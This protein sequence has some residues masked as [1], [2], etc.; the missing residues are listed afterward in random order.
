MKKKIKSEIAT[1]II[2][3]ITMLVGWSFL[4]INRD[5][6]NTDNVQ[7]ENTAPITKS[8]SMEKSEDK[9]V[10][11]GDSITAL[12]D[13]NKLFGVSN[14]TNAGISGNAT[15]DVIARL[16]GVI[17][18]RPDKLF[19][20]IGINDLLQGKEVDYIV[21]NYG[22]ILDTIKLESP[23]TKIYVESVLPINNDILKS[24]TAS[25]QEILLLNEE[26]KKLAEKNNL[27]Y[28]DLYPLFASS[29][30]K[31]YRKYAG[32]GLHPSSVGYDVWKKA[33][34]QYIK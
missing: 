24:T 6:R 32:D 14:I 16:S 30:N 28:I 20:M 22:I 31:L 29:D 23:G 15:D 13:W 4:V 17:I 33:T 9:I 25:E 11:L 19:L 27:T 21:K 26:I 2:I 34:I 1:G 5:M 3:L 8:K 12:K 10:F 7:L 18:T